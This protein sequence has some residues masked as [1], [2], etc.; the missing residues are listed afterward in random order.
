MPIPGGI[1]PYQ[2]DPKNRM[3]LSP[4]PG[5]P[6]APPMPGYGLERKVPPLP[7]W[8]SNPIAELE[9]CISAF[10]R[11]YEQTLGTSDLA[12]WVHP[13]YRSRTRCQSVRAILNVPA[14]LNAAA[15]AA[16]IALAA[17]HSTIVPIPVLTPA[18][19]PAFT[20]AQLLF[21][22]ASQRGFVIKVK[23][24]GVDVVNAP[25]EALEVLVS[26]GSAGGV[27]EAPNPA[28]SSAL[29]EL[30]QKADSIITENKLLEIRVRNRTQALPVAT[31]LLLEFG[32]CFWEFPVD[33]YTDNKD[34]T[35]LNGGYGV[36]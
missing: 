14:A 4:R 28:I 23:S 27:A 31:P 16:G 24:W 15:N 36:C 33:R 11:V 3:Y 22:I 35:R 8:S 1:Q 34:T 18:V 25:N 7:Q 10:A 17:A 13:P 30:H 32:I 26:G 20:D 6:P 19:A 9:K 29:V 12:P 21:S 2:N 5:I